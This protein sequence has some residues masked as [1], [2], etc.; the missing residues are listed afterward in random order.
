MAVVVEALPGKPHWT[1]VG[2]DS[3]RLLRPTWRVGATRASALPGAPHE[4]G[5]GGGGDPVPF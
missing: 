5:D 2:T 4:T 3:L 1:K